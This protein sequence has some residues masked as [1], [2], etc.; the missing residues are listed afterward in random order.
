MFLKQHTHTHKIFPQEFPVGHPVL[1]LSQCQEWVCRAA[2]PWARPTF[3]SPVC[4]PW[5]V[6]SPAPQ[7]N[8]LSETQRGQKTDLKEKSHL[9]PPPTSSLPPAPRIKK[10]EGIVTL[11]AKTKGTWVYLA[12]TARV[13]P[14]DPRH[15]SPLSS[16]ITFFLLETD[17]DPLTFFISAKHSPTL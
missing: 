9:T 3:Y 17:L 12:L 6:F 15:P 14:Q 2:I 16:D 10:E 13:C 4:F 5:S 8:F 1:F 11:A 7:R